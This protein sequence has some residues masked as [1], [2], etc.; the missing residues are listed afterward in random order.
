V[1]DTRLFI[2][3]STHDHAAST[4]TALATY[5]LASCVPLCSKKLQ[6]ILFDAFRAGPDFE[7]PLINREYERVHD[8]IK[9]PSMEGA[10]ED[11]RKM[12]PPLALGTWQEAALG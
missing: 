6:Q 8:L 5:L 2:I 4:T 3:P 7:R 11:R 12:R 1:T 9:V 10:R